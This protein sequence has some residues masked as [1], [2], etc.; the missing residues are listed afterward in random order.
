MLVYHAERA[1]THIATDAQKSVMQPKYPH[2]LAFLNSRNFPA[3]TLLEAV[4]RRLVAS[5]N[6][7]TPGTIRLVFVT[8][9]I[10]SLRIV[11]STIGSKCT[12]ATRSKYDHYRVRLRFSARASL[13]AA[14]STRKLKRALLLRPRSR[15]PQRAPRTARA[16][17]R[18]HHGALAHD[19][20]D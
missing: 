18:R 12:R 3:R 11:R 14:K 8:R 1:G 10:E 4:R 5:Q 9:V 19:G 2:C 17:R 7:K 16:V 6:A 13:H 15:T 20:F